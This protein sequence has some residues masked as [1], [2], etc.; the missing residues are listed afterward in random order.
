MPPSQNCKRRRMACRHFHDTQT[1]RLEAG[2]EEELHSKAQFEIFFTISSLRCELSPTRTLKWPGRNRVNI[3]SN[4]TSSAY[5]VQ[6]VV[7]Q[8]VRRDSSAIKFDRVEIAFIVAILYRLKPL[9]DQGG[10]KTGVPGET[11]DDGL[12]K[13]PHTKARKFR[14]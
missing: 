13:L 2:E 10:E 11:P 12:Q 4:N 8:L 6:H 7:C 5:H 9:T 3:T 14:P 1:V